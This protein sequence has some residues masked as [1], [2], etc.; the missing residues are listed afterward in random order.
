MKSS[1]ASGV[2]EEEI[3]STYIEP[4]RS[5]D[6]WPWDHWEV[7]SG[8]W[9]SYLQHLA[10]T[11]PQPR[12]SSFGAVVTNETYKIDN[13]THSNVINLFDDFFPS[14][15]TALNISATPML[16][17]QNYPLVGPKLRQLKF[18]PWQYPNNITRHMERM[19]LAMTNTIRSSVSR[20]M[21]EGESYQVESYISVQWA[22]LTF[23]L[24][25]LTLSLI[26]LVATIMKTSSDG[27]IGF[28]KTSAMPTLIYSLPKETQS[29]FASTP[30][31]GS[32]SGAPRKTRIKLL[33]NMGWRVSGQSYRS[34]SPR[35]PSGERVPS[36]WL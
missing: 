10:L 24:A 21:L 23:P 12:S 35:L 30:T 7:E 3:L 14:Y 32:G 8:T 6:K 15:Y 5:T 29:Q 18:N 19:A 11:P 17:Y 31:W 36:G 27:A 33:P 34:R 2:Y 28:W 22:W 26:F 20:D 1:Y 13:Y 25:L 16:R 9:F 4:A